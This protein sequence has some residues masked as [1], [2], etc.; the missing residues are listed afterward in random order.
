[1]RHPHDELIRAALPL[2]RPALRTYGAWADEDMEQEA[3]I[4]LLTAARTWVDGRGCSWQTWA[5]RHIRYAGLNTIR[6]RLRLRRGGGTERVPFDEV[7]IADETEAP[8]TPPVE[9]DR[10]RSRARLTKAQ[11]EVVDRTLR[12]EAQVEIAR[13][14]G[15]APQAVSHHL[16]RATAKLRAVY[17]AGV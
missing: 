15:V 3:R 10:F 11:D 8:W 6:H 7:Q 13:A 4:F 9:L 2:V 1:M 14:L 12:G 5:F 16:K 17:E